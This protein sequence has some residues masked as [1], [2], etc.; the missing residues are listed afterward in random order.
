MCVCVCAVR[1]KHIPDAERFGETGRLWLQRQTQE[2][3]D[4]AGRAEDQRRRR[5]WHSRSVF[6][7]VN[8]LELINSFYFILFYL[9]KIQEPGKL[10]TSAGGVGTPGLFGPVN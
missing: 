8:L 10:K 1:C 2:S 7:L 4:D 9:F 3:H 5:C 6:C